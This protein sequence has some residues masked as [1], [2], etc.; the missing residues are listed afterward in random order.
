MIH[1]SGLVLLLP[2]LLSCGLVPKKQ[3]HR[4]L[5]PE[6]IELV[7]TDIILETRGEP[8][9]K[10]SGTLIV[11]GKEIH[12]DAETPWEMPMSLYSFEGEVCK[13]SGE[14]TIGFGIRKD[15]KKGSGVGSLKRPNSCFR[16]A[17]WNGGIMMSSGDY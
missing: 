2:L 13:I 8:G 3:E 5:I 12:I 4:S 6:G 14:G 7:K 16:I 1:K 11:D 9:Q 15:G 10:F 17:Y